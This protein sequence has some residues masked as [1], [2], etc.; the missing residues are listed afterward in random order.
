MQSDSL[1]IPASDDQTQPVMCP[2]TA[3]GH[4]KP[5]LKTSPWAQNPSQR[6]HLGGP[7]PGSQSFVQPVKLARWAVSLGW[8]RSPKD[9]NSDYTEPSF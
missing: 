6:I 5:L 9:G 3:A 7:G 1:R 2:D 8:P 4:L